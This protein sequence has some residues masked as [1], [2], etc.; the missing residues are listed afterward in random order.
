MTKIIGAKSFPASVASEHNTE[1]WWVC[2]A[3]ELHKM[4]SAS[5]AAT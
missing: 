5:V 1:H 4:T 2:E 3:D